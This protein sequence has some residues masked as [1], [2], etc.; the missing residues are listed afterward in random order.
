MSVQESAI[1]KIFNNSIYHGYLRFIAESRLRSGTRD[2]KDWVRNVVSLKRP[3]EI[4]PDHGSS[5][6]RVVAN[7]EVHLEGYQSHE[8]VVRAYLEFAGID[9]ESKE[10]RLYFEL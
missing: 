5:T 1:Q 9:P 2:F 7:R 6:H 10:G 4:A 8:D 3:Y